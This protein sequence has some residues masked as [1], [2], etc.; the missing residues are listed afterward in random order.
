MREVVTLQVGQCGNQ[1]GSEFW[2]RIC[3]E[4]G[5]SAEGYYS[6][7]VADDRKDIFFYEADSGRYVPRVVRI[8]LEP[9]AIS[10]VHRNFYNDDNVFLSQDGCGAGNNW[11]HGYTSGREMKDDIM[12]TCRREAEGCDFLESYFIF[13]SVA[14]GTGSGLGSLLIEEIH[15]DFP[16]KILHTYSIFPNNTEVSDVVVQP[17]NSILTLQRLHQHCDSVVVMDNG[18]LGGIALNS[19]KI[20]IPSHNQINSLISTVMSASTSTMRFPT[21]MFSDMSSILSATVPHG[22]LKFLVPSYSPFVGKESKISR[23]LSVDEILR[24]LYSERTRMAS[25]DTS[26]MYS[27]I[28]VLNILNNVR[29]VADAQ[30]ALLRSFDLSFVP[31]IPPFPNTVIGRDHSDRVSGLSLCNYTGIS[32]LFGKICSQYDILKQRNAYIEGYRRFCNDMSIFDEA[33][34]CVQSLVEEYQSSELSSFGN[35]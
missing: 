24:R 10:T 14:G 8:D 11:A 13:H 17:Y 25:C 18:A 26:K 5:I 21:Y 3:Q 31:W 33:R 1:I 23:R 19:L 6:G 15:S 30:R 34:E 7:D 16:K 27:Y 20:R 22:S 9:R 32:T 35:K 2:T 4:H 28:S 29:D 12:E